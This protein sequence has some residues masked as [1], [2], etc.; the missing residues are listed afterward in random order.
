MCKVLKRT[1]EGL[2]GFFV[3]YSL[4]GWLCY[5]PQTRIFKNKTKF[6]LPG[7]RYILDLF[8]LSATWNFFVRDLANKY[9]KHLFQKYL[10]YNLI[11]IV[12]TTT[13]ISSS[14]LSL[15]CVEGIIM[16]GVEMVWYS[17]LP[18]LIL[19][20]S[21]CDDRTQYKGSKNVK[22]DILYVP[23]GLYCW[24]CSSPCLISWASFLCGFI[25]LLSVISSVF[26]HP[27]MHSA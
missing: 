11:I 6:K 2:W 12:T 26:C 10:K 18:S 22:V 20:P 8:F 19:P 14:V 27:G 17:S 23:G 4:K 24:F 1:K 21:N 9:C 13:I 15:H 7:C 5:Y 25:V 16:L 3:F